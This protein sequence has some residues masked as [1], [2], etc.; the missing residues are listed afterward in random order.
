MVGAG[1]S[2]GDA[3]NGRELDAR[4]QEDEPAGDEESEPGRATKSWMMA[5]LRGDDARSAH[6]PALFVACGSAPRLVHEQFKKH[7]KKSLNVTEKAKR[8]KEIIEKDMT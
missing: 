6:S 3:G 5:A 1:F 7:K 2:L 4:T 8:K